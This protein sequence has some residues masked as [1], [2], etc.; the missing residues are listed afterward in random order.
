MFQSRPEVSEEKKNHPVSLD[1]TTIEKVFSNAD[2]EAFAALSTQGNELYNLEDWTTKTIYKESKNKKYKSDYGLIDIGFELADKIALPSQSVQQDRII[3]LSGCYNINVSAIHRL[4]FTFNICYV[5]IGNFK[6]CAESHV[7]YDLEPCAKQKVLSKSMK[8]SINFL[9]GLGYYN[10]EHFR[11]EVS[12]KPFD[13]KLP[14]LILIVENRTSLYH[15]H[16][17]Y[18]S[19]R[20]FKY[21]A[22]LFSEINSII[23]KM[24]QKPIIHF[25]RE[26]LIVS[27]L[28]KV[29]DDEEPAML[30]EYE[31]L[32]RYKQSGGKV[33]LGSFSMNPDSPKAYPVIPRAAEKLI[34]GL[35]FK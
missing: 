30:E 4:Q 22:K 29:I 34:K 16:Y 15:M 25:V 9:M 33:E 27:S 3:F 5:P 8:K 6:I 13:P 32:R 24:S 31:F 28:Q 26:E 20:N 10:F 2:I 12:A 1:A 11:Q 19:N 18:T 21:Y 17:L 7:Q 23:N 35:K 14:T